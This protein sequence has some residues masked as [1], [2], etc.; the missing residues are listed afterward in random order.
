V[1]GLLILTSLYAV[2]YDETG[3][4]VTGAPGKMHPPTPDHVRG[5]R[6]KLAEN[7]EVC[8]RLARWIR[9]AE[10]AG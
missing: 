9:D 5:A 4:P 8:E 1:E 2:A 7:S 6:A 3:R 10:G